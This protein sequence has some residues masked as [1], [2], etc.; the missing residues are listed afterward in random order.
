MLFAET[1]SSVVGIANNWRYG[2]WI[3]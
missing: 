1:R 3:P 2:F